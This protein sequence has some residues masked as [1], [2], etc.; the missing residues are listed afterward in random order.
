M[1]FLD[2]IG[3]KATGAANDVKTAGRVVVKT[4]ATKKRVATAPQAR[5]RGIIAHDRSGKQIILAG[6]P[7]PI[8]VTPH[9]YVHPQY[10]F[11]NAVIGPAPATR[12]ITPRI[13]SASIMPSLPSGYRDPQYRPV[14]PMVSSAAAQAISMERAAKKIAKDRGPNGSSWLG[15]TLSNLA[16]QSWDAVTGLPGAAVQMVDKFVLPAAEIVSPASTPDQKF[17]AAKR[18]ASS[19]KDFAEG[20]VKWGYGT[21]TD[22]LTDPART[23][24][25]RPL[26]V[27]ML[28]GSAVS[29]TG[30]AIRGAA[31]TARGA[32][33]IDR[34]LA[35]GGVRRVIPAIRADLR[36][37][38]AAR[39][40]AATETRGVRPAG[41]PVTE[42]KPP[43]D[44]TFKGARHKLTMER[45][46]AEVTGKKLGSA[47]QDF[48]AGLSD[49]TSKSTL[50][51]SRRYRDPVEVRMRGGEIVDAKGRPVNIDSHTIPRGPRSANPITRTLQA[52]VTDKAVGRVLGNVYAYAPQVSKIARGMGY[53][54]IEAKDK[55]VAEHGDLYAKL[56]RDLQGSGRS[57]PLPTSEA[58][59]ASATAV[60][61]N[62]GAAELR[63]LHSIPGRHDYGWGRDEMIRRIETTLSSKANMSRAERKAYEQTAQTLREIPDHWLNPDT[64]PAHINRF[65]EEH[66]KL[67]KQS[68][69]LNE[70]IGLVSEGGARWAGRRSQAALLGGRSVKELRDTTLAPVRRDKRRAKDFRRLSN[71]LSIPR[72][73]RDA[74]ALQAQALERRARVVG[75]QNRAY[76]NRLETPVIN[77]YDI[78]RQATAQVADAEHSLR[79]A[80]VSGNAAA[81]RAATRAVDKARKARGRAVK[82]ARKTAWVGADV[83][84]KLGMKPGVYVP[85]QAP[86]QKFTNR[87]ID[88]TRQF[89]RDMSEP[90]GQRPSNQPA[91]VPHAP[92]A[93]SGGS[94]RAG[95]PARLAPQELKTN[96]GARISEGAINLGPDVPI[97]AF[98]QAVDA[99]ERTRAAAQML[100]QFAVRDHN[101][102]VIRGEKAKALADAHSDVLETI[103][104][105]QLAKIAKY[106]LDSPEG[107]ALAE[108]I[109]S[110]I[111]ARAGDEFVIP[112][113]V[114]QGWTTA[115]GRATKFGRGVDYLN[116]LWKGGVLALSPRWYVQNMIGMWG[117]FALGAGLDLQAVMM[118]RQPEFVRAIPGRIADEG[119]SADLG[120]YARAM[121]GRGSNPVGRLIRAGFKINSTLES[122]PRQAM[123]WHAAKR[124]LKDAGVITGP[125]GNARLAEAWLEVAKKAGAGDAGANVIVDEAI[126]VTERFMGNYSRYNRLEKSILRRIFPFYGWMRAI[127]R[128]AFALPVKHPKRAALMYVGSQM[129]AGLAPT[130]EG[131]AYNP[132]AGLV[133][134]DRLFSTTTINPF[135]SLKDTIENVGQT[136]ENITNDGLVSGMLKSGVD[137]GKSL[138]QQSGPLTSIPY[139][140]VAGKTPKDVPLIFTPGYQ[141][142]NPSPAG[143]YYTIGANGPDYSPPTVNPLE[144]ALQSFPLVNTAR[145][146]FAGG[147][148]YANAGTLDLAQ[149]FLGGRSDPAA[150]SQLIVP[151]GKYP[152]VA[153]TDKWSL[154]SNTLLGVSADKVDPVALMLKRANDLKYLINSQKM[155]ANKL[156]RGQ[157]G[158]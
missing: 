74:Y 41:A 50:P 46:A 23:I 148:P 63:P 51:G 127:H 45:K 88:T 121:A 133:F 123:F 147:T 71:D 1:A 155:G 4:Q 85:H 116:S 115:L 76:V 103:T 32:A 143:G 145:R 151:Q 96:T 17:E 61:R 12:K 53:G 117:Q 70:A 84:E 150:R 139:T 105:R 31:A 75:K 94:G 37:A 125:V 92:W 18:G 5:T 122:V 44:L 55:A 111:A 152:K 38:R 47:L 19:A 82:E 11:S 109:D 101:G 154:L 43:L 131:N 56:Y 64:A 40:R 73:Q 137:I 97:T 102:R 7:K 2:G 138:F 10:Q 9:Q 14:N 3:K 68:T 140:M 90:S 112:K 87:L 62:M 142:K 69:S 39:A 66:K 156:A 158:G 58:R 20:T 149:Y 54:V 27:A 83:P 91:I 30:A 99:Q 16:G 77:Q 81:V 13:E 80:S 21:T 132:R 153:S 86:P 144:A 36:D 49:W 22:L 118:A 42:V 135:M 65:V 120:E 34:A 100:N 24:H 57:G 26:D 72:A 104:A 119:L 29:G 126:R 134:G 110:A 25:D 60:I 52:R 128:L 157:A 95:S 48:S 106:S 78:V 28:L 114:M 108:A 59:V 141:G 79:V 33:Y 130:Q 89:V 124:Q 113:A 129:A 35:G 146:F 136:G 107:K 67:L 98:S 93:P 6:P 15:E 8:Q